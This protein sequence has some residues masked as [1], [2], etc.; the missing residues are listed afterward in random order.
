MTQQPDGIRRFG[1][2]SA[3][4]DGT[5]LTKTQLAEL[6]LPRRPGPIAASVEGRDFRDK[7]LTIDLYRI[8]ESTPSPAS[9]RQLAAA[10]AR[11][12]GP[13]AR[14]CSTCGA[15][16]ERALT[17]YKD[18]SRLCQAC[19]HIRSLSSIQR[20]QM[21]D[22]AHAAACAAEILADQR[23]VIV[24]TEL[25][26]RGNTP[27]GVRRSPAA[28]RVTAVDASGHSVLD[29]TVRL[30]GKRAAG[31][32]TGALAPE[33]AAEPIRDAVAGRVLL[34]WGAGTLDPIHQALHSRGWSEALPTG[35]GAYRDLQ[36]LTIRWRAD[37]DPRTCRV[38]GAIAPGRADRMLYLL[39]QIAAD[40][41]AVGPA[42]AD[43]PEPQSSAQLQDEAWQP[44]G[45]GV[46][47]TSDAPDI[48]GDID[49]DG[50]LA[51][52]RAPHLGF[53]R[54]VFLTSS[55]EGNGYRRWTGVPGDS[56][57]VLPE[58]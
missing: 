50:G 44:E 58:G 41:P 56:V 34:T 35:Y 14:Q 46:G 45:T 28:A 19:A 51:C 36:M 32:P 5:Y 30:V 13:D 15:H 7:K 49:P 27:T 17:V 39:Q 42:P 57:T 33:D 18:G 24:S 53:H 37:I 2:W 54:H 23:L 38:R 12:G 43:L 11:T 48:C 4:P 29:V 6:D 9:V 16:P 26:H 1:S 8:D 3:V 20:T 22:R 21:A 55:D 52:T 40:A 31:V 10:R 47:D 25:I